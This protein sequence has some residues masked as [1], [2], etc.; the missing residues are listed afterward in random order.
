LSDTSS[1][2]QNVSMDCGADN[3]NIG[4]EN[5]QA[6]GG[7]GDDQTEIFAMIAQHNRR[8]SPENLVGLSGR[9]PAYVGV[10]C[11]DWCGV[12]GRVLQRRLSLGLAAFV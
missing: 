11:D 2:A 9:S 5:T 7:G 12:T 6:T 3:A 1:D 4:G 8:H 10:E